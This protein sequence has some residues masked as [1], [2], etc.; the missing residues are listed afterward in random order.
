LLSSP[1]ALSTD[2][3]VKRIQRY[4]P[5]SL[6][7][8]ILAQKGKIEGELRQVTIMFCDMRGFTPLTEK[9]GPETTFSL[10]DQVFEILIHKVHENEGTV[11]ELRGDG[12]LALFGAPIALEDAPQKALRSALAI[13]QEIKIFN[14]NVGNGGKF[15]PIL[16][17]IG[18]N[19][20]PVVVGSLGND[21]RV[22]FTAM[23][24]TIN[25]AARMEQMATPGTTY[26]T[27]ETF[28]QTKAFFRFK[29][30]GKKFVKG[31]IS[32]IPVYQVLSAKEN[33]YRPRLGYERI[34]YSEMVGRGRELYTLEQQ[35]KKLINGEGSIVNITG[36]A[37]IGK[38][39][40]IAE[41]KKCDVMRN[42]AFLEGR[43][44]SIGKNLS[45]HPIIDL[46][47]QW[48]RIKSSDGETKAFSKLRAAVK[49]LYPKEYG[50]VLP[51]VAILMGMNLTEQY[52]ERVKGIEGEALE[53]LIQKNARDLLSKAAN[54]TPLVIV[55][56]DLHWCDTSSIELI[57]SL[58]RLTKSHRILHINVFRQGHKETGDRIAAMIKKNLPEGFV[59]IALEPFND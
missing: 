15:P 46:L 14:K 23:G 17:R 2:E 13:H 22:H 5:K 3:K 34:I 38:S 29:A 31:K 36:E 58:L 11:N 8:R 54:L 30:L 18:I 28:K 48:A 42:V 16:L 50:E 6:T 39:R 4:I 10:M 26:V 53:K 9:L 25:M 1:H 59:E 41:L 45:F 56:E 51:F 43:A 33:V 44:I 27:K 24:N 40:L 57:E 12:I 21:L 52:Q 47:K 20:G 32:A 35:I 19:T 37:G 55:L 49:S 7:D